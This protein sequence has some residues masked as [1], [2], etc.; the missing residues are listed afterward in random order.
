MVAQIQRH[1]LNNMS[2]IEQGLFR[3]QQQRVEV[4]SLASSALPNAERITDTDKMTQPN[5]DTT[6][7]FQVINFSEEI[8]TMLFRKMQQTWALRKGLTCPHEKWI[9][10]KVIRFPSKGSSWVSPNTQLKALEVKTSVDYWMGPVF[11]FY[12]EKFPVV[13]VDLKSTSALYLLSAVLCLKLWTTTASS[14]ILPLP[15]CHFQ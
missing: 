3:N 12:L 8:T 7:H 4:G 5:T 1:C 14:Q 11:S 9:R 10:E 2:N 13:G 15:S 6:I